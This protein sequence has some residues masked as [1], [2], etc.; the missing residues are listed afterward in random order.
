M[1]EDIWSKF[2]LEVVTDIPKLRGEEE[3]DFV[4]A[5]ME[6]ETGLKFSKRK[7][8]IGTKSDRNSKYHEFDLVSEDNSIII[9]V[10]GGKA[11]TSANPNLDKCIVDCFFLSKT[12]SKRKILALTDKNLYKFVKSKCDGLFSDIEIRHFDMSK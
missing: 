4:K 9:E 12:T 11:K 10:A 3:E 7:L 1:E 5:K 2:E 6:K 8:I